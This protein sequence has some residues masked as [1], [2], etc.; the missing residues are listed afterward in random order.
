[1][2]T[3]Y[4]S[5]EL[6]FLVYVHVEKAGGISINN[7]LH[8]YVDGYISPSPRWGEEM[9]AKNIATIQKYYPVRIRGVGGHRVVASETYSA[10]QFAFAFAREPL[11]RL[12]SHLNWQIHIMG[13][14]H[15][16]ESFVNNAYFQNFQT[17]R[18]TRSRDFQTAKAVISRHYDFIGLQE[19]YDLSINL[20][21]EK[22]YGRIGQLNYQ[23]LNETQ[24][25]N[26]TYHLPDL[27]EKQMKLIQKLNQTD[28]DVYNYIKEQLFPTYASENQSYNYQPSTIEIPT[29]V[30]LKRKLSNYYIGRIVQPRFM[31]KV[32][33][34]Y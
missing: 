13:I 32:E 30:I 27:N 11:S 3:Y 7:M 21:S 12:I 6:P 17:F 16:F 9:T 18:L 8:N 24:A 29:R 1:M 33:F 22:L 28:I 25:Q 15:T 4:N 5:K 31:K 14:P 23:K 2:K 19:K 10:N 26:K 34:G 20:L